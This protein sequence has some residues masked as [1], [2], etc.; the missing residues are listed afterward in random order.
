MKETGIV[1][2]L[3]ELGRIVIP[4]EIRYNLKMNEGDKVE[5]YIDKEKIVLKKH[6][7]FNIYEEDTYYL[8]KTLFEYFKNSV[9]ITDT[10]K[11]VSGYG[12]LYGKYIDKRLSNTAL[13]YILDKKKKYVKF[14]LVDSV[15]NDYNILILPL[16]NDIKCF[17]SI[18]MIEDKIKIDEDMT[19]LLDFA[20]T[21]FAKRLDV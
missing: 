7:L 3:D 8:S 11:V 9:L 19:L 21:Y 12:Y 14:N 1:R 13:K 17:G 16:V 20:A 10:D 6:T 18:I 5:F 15:E 2:H 4:K